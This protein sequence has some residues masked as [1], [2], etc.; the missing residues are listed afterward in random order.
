[1]EFT[2]ISKFAHCL[3]DSE[4]LARKATTILAGLFEA[5]SPRLSRIAQKMP[6]S[7]EANY[8][9]IQRF[10]QRADPQAALHRLFQV[11]APFVIGDPTEIPRPQARRTQYVGTLKDG[12][13]KGFWLMVLATPF[14]GRA[15]PCGFVTF[16]SRTLA[17]RGESRN[18]HH[19]RAFAQIKDLLGD[20]PLVL[21]RDFSY[22]DLLEHLTAAR[23][24]F[25][26]RLNRRSHPPKLLNAEGRDADLSLK[27]GET[28][29]LRDIRYKG[30]VRLNLIGRWK[31]GLSEPLWVMTNLEPQQGLQIYLGRMKIEQ[32]FRDLKSL[33]HLDQVMNKRQALMEKMVALVLM[34][35]SIGLWVGEGLRDEAY[36]PAPEPSTKCSRKKG[37]RPSKRERRLGR[38]WKRYSGLF[39]LLKQK[40]DLPAE[41]LR[42]VLHSARDS[43]INL[44]YHPVRTYV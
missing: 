33:L 18:Q 42:H 21:D 15:L 25:V 20:K 8:K 13:T 22:L 30:K 14:R 28:V 24:N 9:Q 7:P 34:A 31:K 41:R 11:D 37:R 43:F 29:V 16:S 38:K 23:V 12:K 44:V 39:V 36:G 35:F 2:R 10:L 1:M 27:P 32:S 26:I 3:F 40:L 17:E 5:Q 19:L 6:G 4:P